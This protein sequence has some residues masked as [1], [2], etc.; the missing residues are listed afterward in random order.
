MKVKKSDMDLIHI[1]KNAEEI[2][3][4]FRWKDGQPVCPYCEK[5]TKQY[6]CKDNR[7]KCNHCNRKYSS[8]VKTVFQNSKLSTTQIVCAIFIVL[9]ENAISATGLARIVKVCYNTSWFLIK[10]LQHA[11]VQDTPISGIVA[12]DEV[13]LGGRWKN[14]HW[15]K[16]LELLHYWGIIPPEQQHFNISEASQAISLSKTPVFGGN[17]GDVIFLKIL[18][19]NFNAKNLETLLKQHTKDIDLY[20]SDD[21]G[22]YND[23]LAT[24]EVNCHSRKQ[25]IS[26]N[27]YSSN[28]IEGTFSHYKRNFGYASTHCENYYLQLYLNL[29]VFKWNTRNCSMEES[30][31]C[32]FGYITKTTCRYKDI[33][34]YCKQQSSKDYIKVMKQKKREEE[35]YIAD[36]LGNKNSIIKSIKAKK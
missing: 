10:R 26:P 31:S 4:R 32:L 3:L 21:S 7:Y 2:W 27:G 17:N 9:A 35:Q 33:K 19:N 1:I 12:L 16:K 34:E 24:R 25:Y 18:P 36:Y 14:K 8:R 5:K 28:S 30:W 15:K 22:L 20:I 6:H 13:Y 29:F 11:L 23:I